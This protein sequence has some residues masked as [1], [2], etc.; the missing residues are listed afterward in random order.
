MFTVEGRIEQLR[1]SP[2]KLNLIEGIQKG[3]LVPGVAA[4]LAGQAGMLANAASLALYEGED[5][6]HFAFLINGRLAVGTFEWIEDISNGD[7]VKLVVSDEGGVLYVHALLR[8]SDQLLWMPYSV[9]RSRRG[10]VIDAIKLCGLGLCITWLMFGAFMWIDGELPE[11]MAAYIVFGGGFLIMLFVGF[12]SVQ[13]ML[14]LGQRAEDIFTALGISSP[15]RFNLKNYSL[16]RLSDLRNYDPEGHKK[17]F[18]FKF[19]D[20]IAAHT[21]GQRSEP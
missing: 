18:I 20:A 3:I 7:E 6:E 12:M 19:A 15:T 11:P 21:K 1:K 8:K 14:P 13:G 5:V 10:W 4:A 9:N 2:G 17:G 16:S